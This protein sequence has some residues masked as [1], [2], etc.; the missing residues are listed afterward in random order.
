MAVN[1]NDYDGHTLKPQMEQITVLK[2]GKI[3]KGIADRGYKIKGGIPMIA[4]VIPKVLKKDRYFLKKRHE[5]LCRS[6]AGIEG[7]I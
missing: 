5:E 3:K 4:F 2:G 6:R 1:G 7:F